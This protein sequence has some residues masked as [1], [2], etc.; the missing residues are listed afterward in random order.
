MSDRGR[1]V[2]YR[3]RLRAARTVRTT[4]SF[5]RA[6]SSCATQAAEPRHIH[7]LRFHPATHKPG[8]RALTRTLAGPAQ[9]IPAAAAISPKRH[10]A[11]RLPV[12]EPRDGTRL[13]HAANLEQEWRVYAQLDAATNSAPVSRGVVVWTRSTP[14]VGLKGAHDQKRD[15]V[16]ITVPD[17]LYPPKRLV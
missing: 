5:E 3:R 17:Q 14:A 10:G 4:S 9:P 7:G 15:L 1:R 8:Y 12:A 16:H 6:R 11:S 13:G 2:R